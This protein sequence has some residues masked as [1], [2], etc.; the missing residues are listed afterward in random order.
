[1]Y[2]LLVGFYS[3]LILSFMTFKVLPHAFL[4]SGVY[5]SSFF[6]LLGVIFT[7]YAEKKIIFNYIS[8]YKLTCI[9]SLIVIMCSF[10]I[11]ING[12]IISFAGGV[13]LYISSGCITLKYNNEFITYLLTIIGG[14]IGVLISI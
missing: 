14:L 3:G 2:K 12:I 6:I 8:M 13:I 7:N 10:F 5:R 4:L 9:F 11:N 1:M